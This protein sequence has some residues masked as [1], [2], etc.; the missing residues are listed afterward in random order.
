MKHA[1][2]ISRSGFLAGLLALCSAAAIA[3]SP[4]DIESMAWRYAS[5]ANVASGYHAYLAEYPKGRFAAVARIKL[6]GLGAAGVESSGN[7]ADKTGA[8]LTTAN[9]SKLE[10]SKVQTAS[11]PPQPPFPV[12]LSDEVWAKIA[13][14]ELLKKQPASGRIE[15]SYTHLTKSESAKTTNS[16]SQ[17]KRRTLSPYAEDSHLTETIEHGDRHFIQRRKSSLF[18]IGDKEERGHIVNRTLAVGGMPLFV[19]V[20]NNTFMITRIHDLQGSL[21]PM[22]TGNKLRYDFEMSNLANQ[23]H[24][25][26][27]SRSC[28]VGGTV[29]ASSIRK[30]L[31][32]AAWTIRCEIKRGEAPTVVAEHFF[33]ETLGVSTTDLGVWNAGTNTY[34]VPQDGTISFEYGSGDQK[35]IHYV[36]GYSFK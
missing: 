30:E 11:V 19:I 29:S 21:F 26:R 4:A 34:V 17:L 13:N 35:Q 5:E 16:F 18:G 28:E 27:E 22:Q 12:N 7:A 9:L 23:S 20:E 10:A 3:E 31:S 24:V 8:V 2:P 14:S 32:G 25:V 33:I 15:V 1:C 6:A 36:E